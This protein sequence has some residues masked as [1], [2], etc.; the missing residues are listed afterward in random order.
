M[1]YAF[2]K[3]KLKRQHPLST[4][5]KQ[6]G[7]S[8]R[9]YYKWS[10]SER[11]K[12]SQ[13]RAL[14]LGKIRKSHRRSG[15]SYGSPRVYAQLKAWGCNVSKSTVERM[16]R[17]HGIRGKK[18]RSYKSCTNS[19]HA[20]PVAP[21]IL[22]RNFDQGSAN[23]VWLCDITYLR[24]KSGFAYLA[25]VLDGHSRKVVG[26]SLSSRLH[27]TLAVKALNMARKRE[28]PPSGLICHSDRGIQYASTE[29]QNV[30]KKNHMVQSMSRKGNCWDNAPVESFFDTLKCEHPRFYSFK[31]IR[32]LKRSLSKWMEGFYNRER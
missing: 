11:R 21:N 26:W 9:G 1:K 4:L 18:C 31:D 16:M 17:E 14:L 10:S 13:R 8:R 5:C 2:I 20:Y 27:A 6:L 12:T 15:G 32:D 7:V 19:R 25:A 28:L 29:Y 24:T 23:K 22:E 3:E 30:L